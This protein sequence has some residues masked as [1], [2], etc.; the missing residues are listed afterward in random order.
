[1]KNIELFDYACV[2][3]E[4]GNS[5]GFYSGTRFY[6]RN[7]GD[8][9]SAL[10]ACSI[11]GASFE[12]SDNFVAQ[13]N[14]WKRE[15]TLTS[16]GNSNVYDLVSRFVV[17]S[18]DRPALI[19]GRTI[20]HRD[21]NLY[22][23]HPVGDVKVPVGDSDWIEFSDCGSLTPEGFDLVFYVRDEATE[24]DGMKRWVVHHRMIA[25][26]DMA[27]LVLKGCHKMLNGPLPLQFLIP[28]HIK[29]KL[30]RIRETALPYF[31]IMTVGE[32]CV[33]DGSA[34]IVRTRILHC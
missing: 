5:M 8:A 26:P 2:D 3:F 31:P 32:V 22:Y 6:S 29:F 9:G 14:G 16:V 27:K 33:P 17:R 28:R 21:S 25:K 18:N 1:M 19:A 13:Q 12:V 24:L 7:T 34:A 20:A 30:Y 23:Q 11:V 4:F 10:R 15:L